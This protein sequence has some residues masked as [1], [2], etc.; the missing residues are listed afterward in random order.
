MI[1]DAAAAAFPAWS[2]TGPGVRRALLLKAAEA[3]ESRRTAFVEAMMGEIGA[4]PD[5]GHFN[6]MLAG[7]GGA[8]GGG[9]D[10]ADSAR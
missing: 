6:I 9:H 1:A 4:T 7:L 3:L 10:H 2:Q 5:F 8:R